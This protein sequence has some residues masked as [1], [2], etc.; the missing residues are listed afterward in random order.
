MNGGYKKTKW[1]DGVTP[2][3]AANLNHIEK[4]ISDLYSSALGVSNVQAGDGIE[5]S[6]EDCKLVFSVKND[7]I[8]SFS[9]KGI[10]VITEVPKD[11]EENVIYF[12]VPDKKLTGIW[13]NGICI[14]E[15]Q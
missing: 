3:N 9:V 12:I 8:R 2:V 7:I 1:V 15:M 5:I 11:F 14:Y 4:G 13:L 6:N 10:E